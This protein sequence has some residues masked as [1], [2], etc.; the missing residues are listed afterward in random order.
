ML[1]SLFRQHI[2]SADVAVAMILPV[3]F[4]SVLWGLV[5]GL[6]SSITAIIAFDLFFVPPFFSFAIGNAR[7]YIPTFLIFIVVGVV[8]S[9]LEDVVR[10]QGVRGRQRERFVS[11]LY[12]FSHDLMAG[13]SLEEN[14]NQATH[15]ISDAFKCD[16]VILTP[17]LPGVLAPRATAGNLQ[18]LNDNAIG[19][20]LWTFN[21]EQPAGHGTETL[22]QIDWSFF[23]LVAH[24]RA[25]GVLGIQL[26]ERSSVLTFEQRQ[27]LDAFAN[28]L[29]L[30]MARNVV[31]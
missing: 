26:H 28:M 5:A 12:E 25:L 16:V 19:V 23:P 18:T 10:K 2:S 21:Q 27:L 17:K 3:V 30:F 31:S 4:S 20:A 15:N 1:C 22:S 14:L 9:L 8:T 6:L 29:A 13:R 11:T 24:E 7:Q